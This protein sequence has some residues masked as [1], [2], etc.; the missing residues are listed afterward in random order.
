M[1][2]ET[3]PVARPATCVP[4]HF[5]EWIQG[6]LGP[7]GPVVLVTLSCPA[8]CVRAPG[9]GPRLDQLF[10][11]RAV[12][13]FAAALGLGPVSWPGLDC[14]MPL[15]AGAGASTAC[16]VASARALGSRAAPE[17]L[18]RA[19]L[20]VEGATDPLMYSGPDAMLWASREGCA[21]E[22]MPP[23]PR[24]EI[25]GG[26]W[27]A[28]MRTDPQDAAF[29]DVAD[30]VTFWRGAVARGDRAALAGIASE[31]ARRCTALRGPDDPMEALARAL[32][33]LGHVR[34]HTGTARALIFGPGNVP[35][36]AGAALAEAGLTGALRFV[37]G[38]GA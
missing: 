35:S 25:V 20:D 32:G 33:A 21:L 16:L 10:P 26:F 36:E 11:S 23:P 4:G 5:G 29:P 6:R 14:D 9:S 19:C 34:A 7:E 13:G 22:A 37:T 30:L 38:G 18:A 12:S 27:G 31:S 1:A 2:D 8:L 3:I 15:G 24:C 17:T 28:P